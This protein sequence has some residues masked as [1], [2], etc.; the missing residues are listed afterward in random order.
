MFASEA[1]ACA[2]VIPVFAH[3][4][5]VSAPC[6]FVAPV[7]PCFPLLR[8]FGANGRVRLQAAPFC[9]P[10][11][12]KLAIVE[13]DHNGKGFVMSDA[14]IFACPVCFEPLI[15]KGPAGLNHFAILRSGFQCP[16]CK[17]TYSSREGF[18]DLTIT[19]AAREYK[20]YFPVTTEL[21]RNPIVSFL[22]ERGWRQRFKQSGFPGPDEE[23]K[24]A[25][26]FLRPSA[27]GV[28]LDVSCGTGLFSRRFAKSYSYSTVIAL[29]FSE[30]MLR[31]C[32]EF[33]KQD[34]SLD[35][36]NLPLVRADV[37]RLPF[38]SRTIDAVHSGAALHCW[39]SP[40]AGVA[41]ICRILRP[42]GVFVAT[43]FLAS[44]TNI[45]LDVLMPFQQALRMVSSPYKF[46]AESELQ[47]LSKSCGLVN[48]KMIQKG[49]F[50]MFSASKPE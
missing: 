38:S 11:D 15:R 25:Q 36:V 50:I 9:L 1:M 8:S 13:T 5:Q 20:E 12:S 31:Q 23:F 3:Q 42:G 43:T 17:K 27:G 4:L 48:Y 2:C 37:S 24:M 7:T 46:W 30:N 19:A 10:G 35:G 34:R 39:P 29:D 21:F 47:D 22:Y 40:T 44:S 33:I 49:S 41:E 45:P 18:L 28:L 6:E 16:L 26:E 32:Y 14:E